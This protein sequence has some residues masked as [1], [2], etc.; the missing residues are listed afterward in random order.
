MAVIFPRWTNHLPT[1]LAAVAPVA[2]VVVI[3]AIWYWFSPWFTDVGYQPEQPVA[4]S[5][6]LH[7]GEMGMDCRYCHNTVERAA[8]AAVPPAATCMNCHKVVKADSD[9]LALV[10]DS[11]ENGTAIRWARVHLLPDHAY[12]DHSAHMAAGVGCNQCH[13]RI[14]QMETVTQDQPLSMSWCLD[15]HRA[16]HDKLRPP[17]QVTNMDWDVT[18]ADYTRKT[19]EDGWPMDASGT[20]SLHPP[21]HCS[22]CHR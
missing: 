6:R 19:D 8:A 5:H 12:F 20:R 13:G 15:C 18:T 1:V 16:P 7:A 4:F 17:D 9:K 14:D 10:R 22:G 21:N 3:G 11:A 2:A